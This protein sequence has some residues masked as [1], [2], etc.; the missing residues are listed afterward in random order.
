MGRV[1]E[2]RSE[3]AALHR[4]TALFSALIAIAVCLLL[5]VGVFQG[6]QISDEG[7]SP[8]LRA[9]DVILFSRWSKYL[10]VPK[11]GDVF[12]FGTAKSPSLG[13]VVAL[14]GESVQIDDGN[15]YV[16]GAFLSE[17]VYVQYAPADMDEIKVPEG[18]YFLLPDSRE[19]MIVVPENMCV[20]VSELRG[21]ALIRVS[22]LSRFGIFE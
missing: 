18:S 14:P 6:T 8:T 10:S 21:R 9:G 15:V 7:M 4:R 19:Y 1:D 3:Y 12:A 13:R 16:N 5:F 17:S 2:N 20:P 22:P 11:R